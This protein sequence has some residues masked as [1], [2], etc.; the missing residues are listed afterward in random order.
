MPEFSTYIDIDPYEY[1]DSCSKMEI[2]EII[3]Y[4]IEEGHINRSAAISNER[5]KNK[6]IL[7]DEWD[8]V[9]DKLDRIRLRL[10]TDDEEKIKEIVKKY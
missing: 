10:T 5:D 9:T 6:N 7:D 2:R 8:E 1:I 4:L 3:D